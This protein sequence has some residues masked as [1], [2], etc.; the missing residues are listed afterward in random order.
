MVA[1]CASQ[2]VSATSSQGTDGYVSVM[3]ALKFTYFLN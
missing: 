1:K 2:K 3:A